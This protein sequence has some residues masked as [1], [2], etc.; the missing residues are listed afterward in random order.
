[1]RVQ[2]DLNPIF[3]TKNWEWIEFTIAGAALT[4][5]VHICC[6]DA[7]MCSKVRRRCR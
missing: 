4:F 2:F 6:P 1:M 5:P 7:C 3:W